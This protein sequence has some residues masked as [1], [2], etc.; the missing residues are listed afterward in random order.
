MVSPAPARRSTLLAA[1][2]QAVGA[3]GVPGGRAASLD[4]ALQ[5]DRA[6]V[7]VAAGRCDERARGGA[8]ALG[9]SEGVG[10]VARRRLAG[11]PEADRAAV[12]AGGASG[13][14]PAQ[15]GVG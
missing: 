15:P 9:L 10:A 4:A 8:S 13:A 6:G 3:S 1:S 12:A 5:R 14:A 11:E 7:R 2:T